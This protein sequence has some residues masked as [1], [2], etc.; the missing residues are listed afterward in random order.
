[1]SVLEF[2]NST[3]AG[4]EYTSTRARKFRVFTA[5]L[6]GTPDIKCAENSKEFF[7]NT[8]FYLDY[9]VFY[10]ILNPL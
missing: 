7:L 2:E 5:L 9:M 4:P 6:Y 3:R 10:Y 8:R 1:M